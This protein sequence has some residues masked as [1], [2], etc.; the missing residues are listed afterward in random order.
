[1]RR[2][3]RATGVRSCT[4]RVTPDSEERFLSQGDQAPS[5]VGSNA[6]I[7]S[8][9][10]HALEPRGP[11]LKRARAGAVFN[12]D[13][14]DVLQRNYFSASLVLVAVVFLALLGSV[15]SF[16]AQSGDAAFAAPR[17]SL[18]HHGGSGSSSS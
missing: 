4:P 3:E 17:T 18:Q 8:L 7:L 2:P 6:L 9:E 10:A 1:M 16:A 14:P 5:S 12:S 15:I 13:L 11:D